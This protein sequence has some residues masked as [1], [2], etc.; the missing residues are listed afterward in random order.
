MCLR[1]TWISNSESDVK[2]SL[3]TKFTLWRLCVPHLAQSS[4]LLK[5]QML[6]N[7]FLILVTRDKGQIK[8]KADWRAIDSPNK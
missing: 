4:F 5:T 7:G 3:V 6:Q 2:R 8:P 1:N